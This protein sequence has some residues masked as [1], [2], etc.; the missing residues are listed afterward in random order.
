MNNKYAQTAIFVFTASALLSS[1]SPG[2]ADIVTAPPVP[3]ARPGDVFSNE[4]QVYFAKEASEPAP[5]LV[6]WQFDKDMRMIAIDAFGKPT[7]ANF[8]GA[9]ANS[10]GATIIAKLAD[11]AAVTLRRARPVTCWAAIPKDTLKSDGKPDWYFAR[12]IKI[13]D[14]GGR[15]RVGGGDSGAPE[16][17]I[18]MRNVVWPDGA[19]GKPSNN[20][21]SIV[22][23][24][25]KPDKP[26]AAE[27]YVWADP[28]AARIGINLRW[29]QASCT[30]DGADAPS[31]VT[32]K[33]FRG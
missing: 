27:A 16:Y 2:L 19:N 31:K 25:H 5:P 8:D 33:T 11:G 30:I 18:R 4:E 6:M 24:V 26:D 17:V 28:G 23:Y 20:R 9:T 15:A 7:G 12:D 14:Q 32:P 21:P 22:L 1:P 3:F 10:D 13:F 29:M